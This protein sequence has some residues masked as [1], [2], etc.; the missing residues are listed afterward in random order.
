MG[1]SG[2]AS[3]CHG[4]GCEEPFTR[5]DALLVS[6]GG[7]LWHT[8]CFRCASCTIVIPD[9]DAPLLLL[10]DGRAV[11][12]ECPY[13]C[14]LCHRSLPDEKIFKDDV[15]VYG[16][17]DSP[18]GSA[19]ETAIL[20]ARSIKRI[21]CARCKVPDTRALPPEILRRVLFF[22]LPEPTERPF[23]RRSTVLRELCLVNRTWRACAQPALFTLPVLAWW[24]QER[25]FL[26]TIEERAELGQLAR[27]L[28][29]GDA[30]KAGR[31]V[32]AGPFKLGRLLELCPAVEDLFLSNLSTV[33]PEDLLQAEAVQRLVCNRLTF[34]S[35]LTSPH[36]SLTYLTQ[37]TL[38]NCD[39]SVLPSSFLTPT[40]LPS[41]RTL[42]LQDTTG[43]TTSPRFATLLP[44][45]TALSTDANHRLAL[46]PF[47]ASATSL[48]ALSLP[49]E[50][51][52]D[53]V[54]Q[55][56]TNL[57]YL[58]FPRWEDP[59]PNQARGQVDVQITLN[60]APLVTI[61][62]E[63]TDAGVLDD[64]TTLVLG[65]IAVGSVV[66]VASI[67]VVVIHEFAEAWEET[68]RSEEGRARSTASGVL[69]P[70]TSSGMRKRRGGERDDDDDA[71]WSGKSDLQTPEKRRSLS[72]DDP[73]QIDSDAEAL[74]HAPHYAPTSSPPHSRAGLRSPSPSLTPTV[75][76]RTSS[77][78]SS[79]GSS[80]YVAPLFSPMQSPAPLFDHRSPE[81]DMMPD[82]DEAPHRN[83]DE[84]SQIGSGWSNVGSEADW[85][86]LDGSEGGHGS[87]AGTPGSAAA[88][89]RHGGL[90]GA[91]SLR[92]DF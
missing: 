25:R 71:C 88:I 2:D 20:V 75:R 13:V 84:V 32:P 17:F 60:P 80:A 74:L 67:A 28:R 38:T 53:L 70:L 45:L 29:V 56:T 52:A 55:L 82:R 41:L 87:Q 63:A 33:S 51:A 54:G 8:E 58:H 43:Q 24:G 62:K 36:A 77:F 90:V 69:V 61:I 47:M 40:T 44:Q 15:Y 78:G 14:C 57:R 4:A 22:V 83:H 34:S 11:C 48:L 23:D 72:E 39:L 81:W 7:R 65:L 76:S 49:G 26:T 1:R 27:V 9:P 5:D 16:E 86:R 85:D 59:G 18:F 35:T 10:S 64:G 37:L 12:R 50:V 73:F 31:S 79:V 68:R 3:Q 91:G 89:R 92:D 30:S 42:V 6:F 19:S 66:L 46:S 21:W